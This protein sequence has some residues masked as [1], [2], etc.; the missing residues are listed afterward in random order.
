LVRAASVLLKKRHGDLLHQP[1]LGPLPPLLGPA[2]TLIIVWT[3]SSIL[4]LLPLLLLLVSSAG[5]Q[6]QRLVLGRVR[7]HTSAP[8]QP[9]NPSI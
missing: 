2:P 5:A 6:A 1:L 4:L 9:S 3:T 7:E 8:F